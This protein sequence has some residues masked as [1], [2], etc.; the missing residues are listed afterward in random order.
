[1]TDLERDATQIAEQLLVRAGEAHFAGSRTY[2]DLVEM[3]KEALKNQCKQHPGHSRY[4]S[5]GC[6][7]EH[8]VRRAA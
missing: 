1:M 3:A 4:T 2:A 8:D 6:Y 5:A 7:F